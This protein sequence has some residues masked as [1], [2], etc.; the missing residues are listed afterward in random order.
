MRAVIQRVSS[1]SVEVDGAVSGAI[2]RGF[3]ALIGV[4]RDDAEG[5][6]IA[7]ATKIA[8]LRVFNDDA[9]DMN[10]SLKDVGGGILAV[11]QFTLYGD[12]R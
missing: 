9:G 12:A 2:E 10:R 4:A 6:A 8:G 3:L 7:M 11:S 5:D 1:A